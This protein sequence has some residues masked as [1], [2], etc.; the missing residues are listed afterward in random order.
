MLSSLK[1]RLRGFYRFKDF[2][3]E[4]GSLAILVL[5][6]DALGKYTLF[7]VTLEIKIIFVLIG[8][9]VLYLRKQGREQEVML[10]DF[11][12]IVGG[13]QHIVSPDEPESL[14]QLSTQFRVVEPQERHDVFQRQL[15]S[16]G[17]LI[18]HWCSSIRSRLTLLDKEGPIGEITSVAKDFND[19]VNSYQNEVV[20]PAIEEVNKGP[21]AK[22][23]LARFNKFRLI[24]N[25][26]VRDA[27]GFSQKLGKLS[28]GRYLHTEF[29]TEE[30]TSREVG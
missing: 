25:D 10:N 27:N 3:V 11:V 30:I 17:R 6:L 23:W 24:Y 4:T 7:A 2:V 18:D 26:W 13:Y 9:F 22:G 16:V 21:I 5:L 15:L 29:I 19:L 12:D 8:L 14:I 28:G 1:R 20:K